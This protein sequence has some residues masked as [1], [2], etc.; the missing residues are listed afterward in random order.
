MFSYYQISGLIPI[1]Y[2]SHFYV[3]R[4]Q[5]ANRYPRASIQ[6]MGWSH[7]YAT[8]WLLW[9]RIDHFSTLASTIPCSFWSKYPP[10]I[11]SWMTFQWSADLGFLDIA[12]IMRIRSEYCWFL[13]S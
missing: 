13:P 2:H 8:K 10:S 6:A 11:L 3:S 5:F 7:W 1:I 9:T 4:W 12:K